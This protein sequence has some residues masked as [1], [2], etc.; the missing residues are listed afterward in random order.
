MLYVQAKDGRGSEKAK[1]SE[2]MT[3]KLTLDVFLSSHANSG[4]LIE[5]GGKSWRCGFFS[6]QL[7]YGLAGPCYD[8]S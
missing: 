5:N 1:E 3:L 4:C 7:N 8:R 2:T 6:D